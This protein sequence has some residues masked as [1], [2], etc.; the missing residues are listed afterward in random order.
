MKEGDQILI[1]IRATGEVSA[2]MGREARGSGRGFE[3]RKERDC[4]GKE[5]ALERRNAL[6]LLCAFEV[7]VESL[8][9]ARSRDLKEYQGLE[10]FVDVVLDSEV[11]R[12]DFVI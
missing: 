3:G 12:R 1:W 2:G 9:I 5:E 10:V 8:Y 7:R 6:T 4:R 11:H